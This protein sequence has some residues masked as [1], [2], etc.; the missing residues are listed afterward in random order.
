MSV[1]SS[2]AEDYWPKERWRTA[3]PESQGISSEIL[4]DLIERLWRKDYEIDSVLIVRNGHVVLDTYNH[5]RSP[6]ALHILYS[7]T[8]SVSSTLIGIAIDKGYIKSIDQPLLDFFPEKPPENPDNRKQRITLKHVLMMATG[9]ECRDS[10]LYR[11]QGLNEMRYSGDWVQH[12]I[13]LPMVEEPGSRFEYCNGASFLLTAIIQKTTGKTAAEFA[14]E[15]LFNPLGIKETDWTW[16]ANPQGITIGYSMLY[17]RPRDMARIGYLFLNNGK[18][19]NRQIVSKQWVVES[20]RYHVS[21]TL[22]PGYGYQWWVVS[23]DRYMAV[24]YAG[25]RILVMKDKKM[26]VVFT[27]R[28]AERKSLLPEGL[29]QGYVVPAVKADSPLPENPEAF[30][31]LKSSDRFFRTADWYA[32]NEKR[33]SQAAHPEPKRKTYVNKQYGFSVEYDAE[34]VDSARPQ[35]PFVFRKAGL[36]GL[37]SI[38]VTVADVPYGL[39][40]NDSQK[41]IVGG[42]RMTGFSDIEVNRKELI[43][44][45]FGTPANYYEISMNHGN[46]ELVTV[47]V[48]VYKD[49][50]LISC[51]AVGAIGT[52]LDYLR[53]MVKSLKMG[54][55]EK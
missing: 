2:F 41:Y 13:D 9:L 54:I 21:A 11:W 45:S 25:Q 53:S 34:M 16:T 12:M 20:T 14:K 43:R 48:I 10:Y 30:N 36:A 15:H 55:V 7:C 40:L 38:L 1:S 19:D 22:T 39:E 27:S 4:A 46:I 37:P 3:T 24:G 29:V 28:L 44:L 33:E 47:G 42:M 18:W 8:K 26:V 32:K 50:K 17:M 6:A 35:P 31:R 23:P 52:H 51:S 5:P 49:K